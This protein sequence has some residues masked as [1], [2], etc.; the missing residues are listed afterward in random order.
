MKRRFT[1]FTMALL[2]SLSATLFAQGGVEEKVPVTI[3]DFTDGPLGWEIRNFEQIIAESGGTFDAQWVWKFS[4]QYACEAGAWESKLGKSPKSLRNTMIYSPEIDLTDKNDIEL[5]LDYLDAWATRDNNTCYLYV[6]AVDSLDLTEPDDSLFLKQWSAYQLKLDTRYNYIELGISPTSYTEFRQHLNYCG[7]MNLAM[8]SDMKIRIAIHFW[9]DNYISPAAYKN[10]FIKKVS[11]AGTME[12][13]VAPVGS[14]AKVDSV[15]NTFMRA[16]YDADE[17]CKVYWAVMPKDQKPASAT[18]LKEGIGTDAFIQSGSFNFNVPGIQK[19]FFIAG[20]QQNTEVTLSYVAEDYKGNM[21]EIKSLN[22]LTTNDL[23]FPIITKL[24]VTDITEITANVNLIADELGNINYR[25]Y[26]AGLE[27]E[28]FDQFMAG[29]GSVQRGYIPFDTLAVDEDWLLEGLELNSNYIV[30]ATVTDMTGNVSDIMKS[31][32]FTTLADETAPIITSLTTSDPSNHA[33]ILNLVCNEPTAGFGGAVAYWS[34]TNEDVTLTSEEVLNRVSARAS[35]M[36]E[37]DSATYNNAIVLDNLNKATTYKIQAVVVD[38][39][40]NVSDVVTT[41]ITT[42]NDVLPTPAFFQ[43]FDVENQNYHFVEV[44]QLEGNTDDHWGSDPT[45]ITSGDVGKVKVTNRGQSAIWQEAWCMVGP[46]DL[47]G[48]SDVVVHSEFMNTWGSYTDRL[49]ASIS[50]KYKGDGVVDLND[51]TQISLPGDFPPVRGVY[52]TKDWAVDNAS[53]MDTAGVYIGFRFRHN[54]WAHN[55]SVYNCNV[56]GISTGTPPAPIIDWV[57]CTP[58]SSTMGDMVFTS[59]A[60][61]RLFYYLLKDDGTG[62]TEPDFDKAISGEGADAFGY[63]DYTAGNF[64]DQSFSLGGL[65]PSTKYHVFTT[66]RS[67]NYAWADGVF[68]DA[69]ATVFETSKLN[70]TLCE[71]VNTYATS[72]TL[73]TAAETSG[74]IYYTVLKPGLEAPA[75]FEAVINSFNKRGSTNYDITD[76]SELEWEITGL[77]PGTAYDVYV[78]V[79]DEDGE[80]GSAVEKV[81]IATQNLQILSVTAGDAIQVNDTTDQY[82]VDFTLAT[83]GKGILYTLVTSTDA[84]VPTAEEIMAGDTGIDFKSIDIENPAEVLISVDK[85][86]LAQSTGYEAWFVLVSGAYQSKVFALNRTLE[87]T[88]SL[89]IKVEDVNGK[90]LQGL[91]AKVGSAESVTDASGNATFDGLSSGNQGYSIVKGNYTEFG[92][93]EL[94]ADMSVAVTI[95]E[96]YDLTIKVEDN[97]GTPLAEVAVK[98]GETTLIT[99]NTGEVVFENLEIGSYSYMTSRNAVEQTADVELKDDNLSVTVVYNLTSI[100]GYDA[101]LVSVYPNPADHFV[102]ISLTEQAQVSVI[103]LVGL[104]LFE[105][106][107][108][109]GNNIVDVTK[110]QKGIYLVNVKTI[111]GKVYVAKLVVN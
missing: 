3:F 53:G 35:G 87:Y 32:Y 15:G 60:Y 98:V 17:L 68:Y 9:N 44:V 83:S 92:S 57:E 48:M 43:D 93:V 13:A 23:V 10:I 40:G 79:A 101:S 76:G 97:N 5:Y 29:T 85:L 6:Q 78:T 91:T 24:E 88:Y 30:Y 34:A 77:V 67:L 55:F 27:P 64:I 28:D 45:A 46:I 8:F 72:S 102:T 108:S 59:N 104:T 31:E 38:G 99:D 95:V 63:F 82:K 62:V 69:V 42:T 90:P 105:K 109:E 16:W 1:L 75:D 61:G 96:K 11:L 39:S 14:V 58:K 103:N 41:N 94:I 19:P 12:D 89:T 25:L 100:S 86:T 84:A 74:R 18:S 36:A 73:K 106:L 49:T 56:S 21:A 22:Q 80:Y 26:N 33:G 7:P 4:T 52:Q 107:M 50:K 51:W 110:F 66:F 47:S 37:L 20:L 54:Q 2:M 81:E 111:S 71:E 65:E 70:M